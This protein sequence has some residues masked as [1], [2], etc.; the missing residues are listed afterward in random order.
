VREWEP[1]VLADQQERLECYCKEIF[2]RRASGCQV[3][4]GQ[5]IQGRGARAWWVCERPL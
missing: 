1:F 2:P 5:R 3:L 4:G